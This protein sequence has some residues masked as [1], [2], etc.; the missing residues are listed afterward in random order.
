MESLVI[1]IWRAGLKV[2]SMRGRVF[3]ALLAIL[4]VFAAGCSA[5]SNQSAGS[6][7]KAPAIPRVRVSLEEAQAAAPFDF[8]VPSYFPRAGTNLVGVYQ[9]A[10]SPSDIELEFSDGTMLAL[11][12]SSETPNWKNSPAVQSGRGRVISFL[13]V[14]A[15]AIEP[16]DQQ[17]NGATRHYK[18][19]LEWIKNGIDYAVYGE[20]SVSE[21]K[22]VGTSWR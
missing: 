5:S 13:G 6:R 18:G 17:V 8:S 2:N 22:N 10:G 16:G 19:S 11:H 21:L 20:Y 12:S 3:T 14:S 4:A 9:I 7:V 1:E 15:L